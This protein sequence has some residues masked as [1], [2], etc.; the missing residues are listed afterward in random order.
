MKKTY[1]TPQT[2]EVKVRIANHLLSGSP[3]T[4]LNPNAEIEEND[5][6]SREG[7]SRFDNDE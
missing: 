5:F 2:E 3:D 1:R 7:G 6:A 4:R